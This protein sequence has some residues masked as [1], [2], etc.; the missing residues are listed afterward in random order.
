MSETPTGEIRGDLDT[1]YEPFSLEP[2]YL[3]L[4][5]AF[6]AS[7]PLAD[8]T[9]ILDIACGTG[10]V[11]GL[12][13]DAVVAGRGHP[14]TVVGVDLSEESLR[15][16]TSTFASRPAEQRLATSFVEGAGDDVPVVN[17]W[18]DLVTVGNAIHM[19]GDLPRLLREIR[20]ALALGGVLAFNTSFYAGTFGP[21]TEGFYTEWMRQALAWL[22]DE[23]A[24]RARDGRPRLRRR[25]GAGSAAFSRP[26]LAPGDY[27]DQLA[28]NGFVLESRSER[29]VRLGRTELEAIGGYAG[30]ATVLLSG[31]PV[32]VAAEAL[33][34]G[35]QPAL[36]VMGTD[37]VPRRWLE[38]V[39]RRP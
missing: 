11:T 29:T 4:N 15:I 18:A 36:E 32:P 8:A 28:G 33:V 38:I 16:A 21:G 20:R 7:L 13:V 12:L 35:V 17:G 37:A 10:V 22:R 25:R 24:R 27:T 2:A 1:S 9:R 34:R 31:Y 3:D 39:A 5:A 26:W 14:P 23:E 19:F 6:V 30:L